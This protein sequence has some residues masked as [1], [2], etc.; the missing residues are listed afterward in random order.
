MGGTFAELI[1]SHFVEATIK[2]FE[3]DKIGDAKSWI[4]EN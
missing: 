1:S 4:L 2:S 3:Y